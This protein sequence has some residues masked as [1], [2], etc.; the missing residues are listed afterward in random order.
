[1]ASRTT[2]AIDDKLRKSIKKIAAFLDIPQGEVIRQAVRLLEKNIFVENKNQ[3]E[4]EDS[5][6]KDKVEKIYQKATESVLASDPESARIQKLLK[7]GADTID[8]FILNEWESG[9]EE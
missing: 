7:Q 3:K 8:D 6:F 9:L 2:V 4:K 5:T 1:M